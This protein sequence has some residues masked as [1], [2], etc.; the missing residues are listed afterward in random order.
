M[1]V[2]VWQR[3]G[4]RKKGSSLPRREK[5]ILML[6]VLVQQLGSDWPRPYL[7]RDNPSY[8]LHIHTKLFLHIVAYTTS[9]CLYTYILYTLHGIHIRTVLAHGMCMVYVSMECNRK[10]SKGPPLLRLAKKVF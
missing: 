5:N 7:W 10:K 1:A 2:C 8:N 4:R 6:V 3:A 9:P